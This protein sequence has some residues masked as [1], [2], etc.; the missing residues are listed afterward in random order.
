MDIELEA[1]ALLKENRRTTSGN[2][3]TVPSA[4]H[5]PYQWLWDSCF[6]AI[7]LSRFEPEAA[8]AEIRSLLSRQ[9][10]TGMLPHI[11]YWTPG[12][13][14]LFPWGVEGTSSLTQP[15]M[16]AYAVR[17]IHRREPD[18]PFLA[19]VFPSLIAYYRFLLAERDPSGQHLVSIINPDES[20]EDNS[21]RF[22]QPLGVLPGVSLK[23]HLAKRTE[24]VDRNRECNFEAGT[25][26]KDFF[27]V[28]DVL[29]N[30]ILVENLHALAEIADHLK[31]HEYQRTLTASAVEVAS[32]MR[33]HMFDEGVFWSTM[34][35][36]CKK[37]KV[38]TWSHF[39][40]L[41]AGLYSKEEAAL[42]VQDHL[43]NADTFYAPYGIRTTSRK[44]DAYRPEADDFSWRG[45][46]WHGQHWFIYKGLMRYGFTKEAE[47]IRAKS[48]ALLERN[49]FREC[50]NPETGEGFGAH[51]FT[52]GTLVL[53]MMES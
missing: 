32:A 27:W 44:E 31:H 14:H 15:P 40:P 37:L 50:F 28:K 3:Y 6:H 26:M 4:D 53:D 52:W 39:L 1:K 21:P 5:Y 49:G 35:E 20:G 9:F 36:D 16:L 18:T 2:Q 48:I 7:I 45:P 13:L 19:S 11:I 30:A 46:I 47:D 12:I 10:T 8:K 25:C 38:A 43:K 34:G 42:V 41:F 22:D 51:K 29:F 24:L 33:A 17:E 23:D